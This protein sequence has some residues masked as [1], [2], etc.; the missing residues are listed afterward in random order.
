MI[1]WD[2]LSSTNLRDEINHCGLIFSGEVGLTELVA[3]LNP[4]KY[5]PS[6]FPV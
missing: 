1:K 6:F 5:P 4:S 3:F 2:K